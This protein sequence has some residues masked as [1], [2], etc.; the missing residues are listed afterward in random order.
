[1]ETLYPPFFPTGKVRRAVFILS[2]LVMILISKVVQDTKELSELKIKL[3]KSQ[4]ADETIRRKGNIVPAQINYPAVEACHREF[5]IPV[6]WVIAIRKA[7][8][9]GP[10]YELGNTK[11]PTPSHQESYPVEYW[12]YLSGS[13]TVAFYAFKYINENEWTKRKFFEYLGERWADKKDA[14]QWYKNVLSIERKYL[15]TAK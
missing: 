11:L 10:G 1:M 2:V 4:W 9:G 12:N 3:Y 15:E 5:G 13:K 8:N 6:S 14:R 7:E